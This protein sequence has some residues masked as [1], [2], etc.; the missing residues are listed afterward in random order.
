MN[1]RIARS[2]HAWHASGGHQRAVVRAAAVLA[3]VLVPAAM[4]A[5]ALANAPNPIPGTT[6]LDS[7]VYGSSG[8]T[9]TIEGQWNWT[10]QPNCAS[11]RNGVGYQLAWFDGNTANPIGNQSSPDGVLYVGDQTDNIVH[12]LET[13]GGSRANGNA[14][15]DGVPSSYLTHNTTDSTPNA[16]DAA[17][18]F[19]NCGTQ[20]PTTK[21]S[22]GSWGPISHTY[23]VGTTSI[24]VCPVM[25]DPHGGSADSGKSTAQDITAGG[26][27]TSQSSADD[28]T[29]GSGD[30]SSGDESSG[31]H[32]SGDE[33]SS[34]GGRK[35]GDQSS[36]DQS[37]G[38]GDH[39]SGDGSSGSDDQSSGDESSGS[40]DQS[41]GDG[42]S[43][44]DESSGSGDQSSGDESSGDG[45]QSSGDESSGDDESGGSSSTGHNTD[46]SYE[47]NGQAGGCQKSTIALPPP[48]QPGTPSGTTTPPASSTTS[49]P[50]T[51]QATIATAGATTTTPSSSVSANA[52]KKHKKAKKA[53]KHKKQVKAKT[54]S[55]PPNISAGFTG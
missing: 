47:G 2:A 30:Q 17:N 55:R 45:D 54:I 35:S 39:S 32:S 37:S 10:S 52:T 49:T 43:G 28:D 38:S 29:G 48:S 12:S 15:W 46:N 16:T 50:T 18:W 27:S 25:Y 9:V 3:G 20:D 24:T 11:A 51:T 8:V 19:S 40:G 7:V 14:F 21:I 5:P 42:S 41:S 53:K 33:S 22:S 31:D 34:S 23:P 36:G 26:G 44:S 1:A 6:K 13:L 4:A